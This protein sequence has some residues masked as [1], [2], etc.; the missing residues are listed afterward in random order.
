[1]SG[2]IAIALICGAAYIIVS[3]LRHHLHMFQQHS[4]RIDR[5]WDWFKPRWFK[6]YRWG[7]ALLIIPLILAF[8]NTTAFAIGEIAIFA[9]LLLVYWP[10]PAKDKKPLVLT[11]RAVR[12]YAV[13]A[14][15]AIL[16][17]LLYVIFP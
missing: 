14:L 7:E 8:F 5:Y 13:A 10:R 12:L 16:D 11:K 9:L 2:L 1:M 15:L 17:T 6:E 4:Y 3:P